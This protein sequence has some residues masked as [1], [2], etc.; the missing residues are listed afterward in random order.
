LAQQPVADNTWVPTS[1]HLEPNN[2]NIR[3]RANFSTVNGPF[4]WLE[5]SR[6]KGKID[7]TP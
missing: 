2:T 5:S 4:Q 7:L 1:A 3:Q 6:G